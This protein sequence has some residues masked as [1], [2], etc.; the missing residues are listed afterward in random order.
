ME[1][2]VGAVRSQHEAEALAAS[3]APAAEGGVPS[4]VDD[5]L[6]REFAMAVEEQK[7]AVK[8]TS[9]PKKPADP[10]PTDK[11]TGDNLIGEFENF[12]K[13]G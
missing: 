3:V 8:K 2:D 11:P 1:E 9:E 6:M 10:A 7:A 12:V 5:D 4:P 13:K